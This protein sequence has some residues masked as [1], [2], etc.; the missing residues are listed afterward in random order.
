MS[1][2]AEYTELNDA[3]KL[4]EKSILNRICC[5]ALSG[6]HADVAGGASTNHS[7]QTNTVNLNVLAA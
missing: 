2:N 1:S 3:Q 7:L 6:D 4:S 5:R